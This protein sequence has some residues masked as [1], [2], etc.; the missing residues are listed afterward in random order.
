[1][2]FFIITGSLCALGLVY[3][4]LYFTP[5]VGERCDCASCSWYVNEPP[6][7]LCRRRLRA[8][9]SLEPA[10]DLVARHIN[11]IE[12]DLV[13]EVARQAVLEGD[14]Q[15]LAELSVE[16]PDYELNIEFT[17]IRAQ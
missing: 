17:E 9:W 16:I 13:R 6:R 12:H 14:R 5:V 1:M 7:S 10:V 15:M 4:G 3:L 2:T 11:E 8:T